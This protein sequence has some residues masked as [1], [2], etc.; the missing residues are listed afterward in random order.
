MGY[1]EPKGQI[2]CHMTTMSNDTIFG[3]FG[4]YLA[5]GSGLLTFPKDSNHNR[6]GRVD[7]CF[8]LKSAISTL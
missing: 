7:G 6:T 2:S 4:H 8:H 1:T 5:F 3:L